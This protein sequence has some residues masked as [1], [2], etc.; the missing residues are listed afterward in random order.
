MC[1]FSST[2]TATGVPPADSGAT[3]VNLPENL[4]PKTFK[5]ENLEPTPTPVPTVGAN[6]ER[7]GKVCP[8]CSEPWSRD[9]NHVCSMANSPMPKSQLDEFD[10]MRD[11]GWEPSGLALGNRGWKVSVRQTHG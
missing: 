5:P 4:T 3:T 1:V 2:S 8:K 7:N 10:D 11:E 9:R 6:G